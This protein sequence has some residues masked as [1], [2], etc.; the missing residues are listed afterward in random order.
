MDAV[1]LFLRV[2]G[3][4]APLGAIHLEEISNEL[5][6][7]ASSALDFNLELVIT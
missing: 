6:K 1:S 7:L 2:E 3:L 5:I 4:E